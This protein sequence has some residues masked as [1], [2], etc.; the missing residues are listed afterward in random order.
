MLWSV[1]VCAWHLHVKMTGRTSLHWL[2]VGVNLGGRC[3]RANP[4]ARLAWAGGSV[5]R[6]AE[7]ERV[8]E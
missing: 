5:I 3:G 8:S 6:H 2:G 1:Y 4:K 7:G